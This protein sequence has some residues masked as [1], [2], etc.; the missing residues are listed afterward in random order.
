MKKLHN[1]LENLFADLND[2]IATVDF[3]DEATIQGWTWECDQHGHFTACSPEVEN[4]LG[5]KS[6]EFLGNPFSRFQL[7]DDSS[8]KIEAMLDR[9]SPPIAV[10]VDYKSS[11]G[12]TVPVTLHILNSP[13]GNGSKDGTW[14]G[15][16]Q[17]ISASDQIISSDPVVFGHPLT[18]SDP[19]VEGSPIDETPITGTN[20]SEPLVVPVKLKD[21]IFGDIE[22]SHDVAGSSWSAGEVRLVEQVADQLSLALENARLFKQTQEA[23]ADSESRAQELV[24]LNEMSRTLSSNLDVGAVVE[25]IYTYTS[26]L[27]DT[28]NFYVALYQQP[29]EQISF[30]LVIADGE[31]V[32]REHPEWDAWQADQPV[33]GLT[34]YV[35]NSRQPLLIKE[36]VVEQLKE[37]GIDYVEVGS[38]GVSSWLGVP[39]SIGDR[40]IGVITVQSENIPNLYDQ[41]HRDLLS[42]I[43]NQAAIAIENARLLEES[44]RRNEELTALNS[45]TSAAS[46]SLNLEEILQEALIQVLKSTPFEA[47]LISIADEGDAELKLRAQYGLPNAIVNQLETSGL[48]GTLCDETYRRG[49]VVNLNDISKVDFRG[50]GNLLGL[51]F[52]SYLGIPLESKGKILGTLC[53]F[54]L[55]ASRHPNV[56]I[57]LAM[58][59]SVG[60]QVGVA[61]VNAQLFEEQRRT[62]HRLREVDKLKS[63][64]LANMSHEL[65]TPLNSIIGFS[66]V[67]LKGIDGP[68]TD[69]QEQDLTAIYNSGQHLLSMIND[70][71]DLSK[72]EAGKMEISFE[73]V[74]LQNLI[75]SVMSTAVGLVKDKPI[76]LFQVIPTDLPLVRADPL[77]IRQVILNL[78]SNAAKFTEEGAI[79][80][81]AQV[82]ATPAGKSEVVISVTDT[83][84]GIAGE[85]HDKLFQPFSQVD[86]SPTRKSGGSGLGL[87]IC[88]ALV[89]MHGGR[90]DVESKLDEGSTFYFTLPLNEAKSAII[91]D[92]PSLG[93]HKV[94]LA[95]ES[96]PKVVDYYQLQLID[97]GYQ[98]IALT[99]PDRAVKKARQERPCAITLDVLWPDEQGW[100]ILSEL[101]QDPTTRDIPVIICSMVEDKERALDLGADAYLTKPI[102]GEDLIKVLQ[103]LNVNN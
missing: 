82:E 64:F 17:L 31:R 13:R 16:T 38:G 44:N 28:Y 58:M 46:H 72:I 81:K 60:Q 35:I 18:E 14:R 84:P 66:R 47:G 53:A 11:R 96:N 85:D 12:T 23:L 74:D 77:R 5:I 3:V 69:L 78:L 52:R 95:I 70:I 7:T 34:G 80:V 92:R 9:A 57:N 39:M 20:G 90:I 51:G 71:L 93:D 32:T 2:E 61:I 45:I 89:E 49:T 73:D 91:L 86:A 54:G 68:T 103:S 27:M 67:I 63:Q 100:Q 40:V 42:S 4:V 55:S 65:R 37:Q 56:E 48:R 94:I 30:P 102:L 1:R 6:A 26:R 10:E 83:G 59:R 50:T 21:A 101:K 99:E 62:A 22:V 76:E 87:S 36:Q 19:F 33:S 98:V 25:K 29:T 79:T 88:R 97:H 8:S 43:G 24:L 75:K 41:H 15:F